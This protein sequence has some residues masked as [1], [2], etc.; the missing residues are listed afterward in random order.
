MITTLPTSFRSFG[1]WCLTLSL[2]ANIFLSTPIAYGANEPPE[3]LAAI[4]K[5]KAFLQKSYS[6]KAI[7]SDGRTTISALALLKANVPP[8]SAPITGAV[9]IITA[10]TSGE[11]YLANERSKAVYEAGVDLMLLEALDHE[12]TQYQK[13]MEMLTKYIVGRQ[14]GDG[15]WDYTNKDAR[16]GDT[17][18]TQYALLGL[19]SAHK[20]GIPFSPSVWDKAALWHIQVQGADGGFSYHPFPGNRSTHSMSVAGA[21]NMLIIR[22]HLYPEAKGKWG[23]KPVDKSQDGTPK[24]F[25]VL[26]EA[27]AEGSAIEEAI[28]EE[29]EALSEV[30]KT[31][32]QKAIEAMKD[33]QPRISLAAIDKSI[34]GA[35]AWINRN[36]AIKKGV[37]QY[38]YYY[39]YSMERMCALGDINQLAGHDWYL[40]GGSW[41]VEK[42]NADK[43]HWYEGHSLEAAATAFGLMFLTKATARTLGKAP[44][45][46]LGGGMLTGNRGLKDPNEP[47]EEESEKDKL[48]KKKKEEP[49]EKLLADLMNPK[50]ANVAAIAEALVENVN[51]EER[52][53]LISQ[54]EILV[55]MAADPRMNVKQIAMWAL[56]RTEDLEVIPILIDGLLVENVDVNVEALLSLCFMT[57]RPNGLSDQDVSPDQLIDPTVQGED[58]L[59][60]VQ[61]WREETYRRWKRWYFT[62][63]P[64]NERDDVEETFKIRA[65]R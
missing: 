27:P 37:G 22:R 21:C 34:G 23:T 9:G 45:F 24:K 43:G 39:L 35:I 53:A 13:Q 29:A 20:A 63:R 52:E 40:E 55:K 19:W 41:L 65:A 59:K 32:R 17:S 10:K 11:E 57:R 25:G 2:S 18:Q 64:Y 47:E 8:E 51:F 36:Y 38:P 56:G 48:V 60:A 42:Q 44:N 50:E 14:R 58:R 31:E 5:A 49:V 61:K 15:A 62:V 4:E 54:K 26:E 1:L 16:N 6:E 7:P 46:G 33:Y 12:G 30:E 28:V 3:F